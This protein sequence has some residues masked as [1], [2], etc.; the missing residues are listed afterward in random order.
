MT[1]SEVPGWIAGRLRGRADSEHE[2]SF[3]RFVFAII[4]FLVLLASRSPLACVG[5]YTILAFALLGHIIV[6]PGISQP[7]RALALLIDCGFLSWQM[8]IGG[9]RVALFFPLYLW[10]IFGNGFRFGIPYL[11]IAIP[12]AASSFGAVVATTPFWSRQPHLSAG[13]LIGLIILPAYAG[14]LIRKLSQATRIAEEASKAKSLFL[15][16]VSHELRTPLTAI[17]GMSGLL[18]TGRLDPEQREMVETVEVAS[19]SLQSLINQLLDLSRIEAGQMTSAEE[20]FDLL[21][22]LIDVRRMVEVQL[23]EKGLSFDIH[24]TP[25]TPSR[26]RTSR[27]HLQEILVN[28]AGNAVKFTATGGIVIAV[29]GQP[30]AGSETDLLLR[31]LVSDTGIG[32]AAGDQAHI[33]KSFTQGNATILNRFGGTG[34]GLAITQGVVRLLGGEID[35]ESALG[36]GSTFRFHIKASYAPAP[37]AEARPAFNPRVGLFAHDPVAGAELRARL[38]SMGVEA[39]GVHSGIHPGLGARR[40]LGGNGNQVLLMHEAERDDA[41]FPAGM[42]TQEMTVLIRPDAE[43]GLPDKATARRCVAL[44]SPQF[45]EQELRQAL[46]IAQRLGGVQPVQPSDLASGAVTPL[47]VPGGS[48]RRRVLVVDDNRVNRRVFTRILEAA[49]HDVLVAENGDAALDVLEKEDR[50]LDLVLMDINMPELD[51]LEATKLYRVIALGTCRP[52]QA[53]LPIIGLTADA[54]AQSD[55]T[56]READMDGCLLKPIAPQDLV[57]AVETMSRSSPA[58]FGGS[59]GLLQDHPRFRAASAAPAATALDKTIIANLRQLGDSE[60]LDELMADF[61]ADAKVLI[62]VLVAAANAGDMQSFRFNAHALRSSAANV[63]ATALGE[64]CAPWI[65]GRGTD[66]RMRAAEFAA[67]AQLELERTREAIMALSAPRRF[68][69]V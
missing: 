8:H 34:L 26:L 13:L 20:E 55:G 37:V 21:T 18:R 53:R 58:A 69:N 43:P 29:D 38:A 67:Q 63:G 66:L 1:A 41:T 60:F 35:V 56:W 12:V 15:A 31:A 6:W 16:S 39:V 14:T 10:V 25:R 23:R 65:K 5:L 27:L 62:G 59:I 54:L 4:V 68:N 50:R 33:F 57:A 64:L 22:L 61:I 36:E 40:Q 32:I 48:S 51:G 30:V 11:V 42:S 24:V 3:N 17:V 49:G 47:R 44:L 28:L 19:R 7:R 2:M 46:L 9:E 52:G 45:S